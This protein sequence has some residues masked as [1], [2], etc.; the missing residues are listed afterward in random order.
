MPAFLK[1]SS[2]TQSAKIAFFCGAYAQG[3]CHRNAR[4]ALLGSAPPSL[5]GNHSLLLQTALPDIFISI[6]TSKQSY[7]LSFTMQLSFISVLLAV[8]ASSVS[9]WFISCYIIWWHNTRGSVMFN[10]SSWHFGGSDRTLIS[11]TNLNG[12]KCMSKAYHML[13]E[14][15]EIGTNER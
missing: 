1:L 6:S 2:P 5:Q 13:H 4:N 7:P 9:P 8:T 12:Y 3:E 14:V 10:F 11:V 15:L